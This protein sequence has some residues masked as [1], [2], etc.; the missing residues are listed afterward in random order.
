MPNCHAF[1]K[2]RCSFSTEKATRTGYYPAMDDAHRPTNP[3]AVPLVDTGPAGGAGIAD[4][5]C[6]FAWQR[7]LETQQHRTPR[8]PLRAH[9][10]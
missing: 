3:I 7:L 9:K 10:G 4:D 8:R 1:E 6:S 5:D 2:P